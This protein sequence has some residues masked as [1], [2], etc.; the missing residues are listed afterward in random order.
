MTNLFEPYDLDGRVL[1]NRIVMAPMTRSRSAGYAANELN[2]RYYQQRAG[3]GLIITEGTP[4]SPQGQGYIDVPAIYSNEQIAGWKVVTDAVHETGGTI[5]AQIWHVGRMSHT[6]LQPDGGAPVGPSDKPVASAPGNQVYAY[7][8]DGNPGQT[9]PSPPRALATEEIPGI[10]E[11]FVKAA[12]NAIKAGFDG[13]EIHAA[14]GYLFEQFLNPHANARDDRYGGSIENRARL[15]LETV[16]KVV[17]AIGADKV[18]IR[19]SPN[20]QLFDLPNYPENKETY[21]YL[22]AELNKRDLA[23]IHLSDNRVRGESVLS[24]AFLKQFKAT[25]GGTVIL[26]GGLT[27]ENA[28]HLLD[29]GLIDLAAFG[30]PFIA[31]PDLVER[32]QNNLPL[33]SP[34]RETYYGGDDKGYTDYA[35]HVTDAN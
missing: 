5:F 7:L 14:N 23:Y 4:V 1:R 25:Y 27:R 13:V 2:A 20:S 22:A 21:L 18:G 31:N 33:N 3:A 8:P 26:A 11:D 32:L 6:S 12:H 28:I 9:D 15:I 10:E 24:E 30:Q 34:D 17:N 29:T 16:D 19:L 35:T